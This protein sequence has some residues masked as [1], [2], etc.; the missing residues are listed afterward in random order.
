M[1]S[2]TATTHFKSSLSFVSPCVCC[3]LCRMRQSRILQIFFSWIYSNFVGF[4]K[5]SRF[6]CVTLYF[7]LLRLQKLISFNFARYRDSCYWSY[8]IF[9]YI[10]D[11]NDTISGFRTELR[12]PRYVTFFKAL[13]IS[14][15]NKNFHENPLNTSGISD[16]HSESPCDFSSYHTSLY[17]P[18][19]ILTQV[20]IIT[21][22][23]NCTNFDIFHRLNRTGIF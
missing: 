19:K 16:Y 17:L 12:A 9:L 20:V 3:M 5:S 11:M 4:F 13:R 23:M 10:A 2:F 18:V 21:Y 6:F 8:V 7:T 15:I 22:K 1:L 14:R